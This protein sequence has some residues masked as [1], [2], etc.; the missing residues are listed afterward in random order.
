MPVAVLESSV[1]QLVLFCAEDVDCHVTTSPRDDLQD[2]YELDISLKQETWVSK[3]EPD[4]DSDNLNPSS[5]VFGV[6]DK[7]PDK[8]IDGCTVYTNTGEE[9]QDWMEV[10][11]ETQCIVNNNLGIGSA[12]QRVAASLGSQM[13]EHAAARSVNP[14][15]VEQVAASLGTHDVEQIAASLGTQFGEDA[16]ARSVAVCMQRASR[17]TESFVTSGFPASGWSVGCPPA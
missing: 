7:D 2:F 8:A 1:V 6:K 15:Y 13:G 17:W 16:A 5:P 3:L 11:H 12:L 14:S 9:L 4:K 10:S